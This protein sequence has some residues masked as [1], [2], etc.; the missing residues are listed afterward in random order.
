MASIN[1]FR[2]NKIQPKTIDLNTRFWGINTEF[3]GFI[4]LSADVYCFRL[5][6]NISKLVYW[7]DP[8]LVPSATRLKMSLTSSSGRTKKFEFFHWLT[9]NECAAEM[10]ITELYAFHFTSGPVDSSLAR[11]TKNAKQINVPDRFEGIV[12]VST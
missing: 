4:P 10:K 2:Y 9:K 7:L 11:F 8:I 3:V 6:F 1:Q 5:N 12:E